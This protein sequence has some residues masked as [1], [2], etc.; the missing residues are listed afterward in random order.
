MGNLRVKAAVLFWVSEVEAAPCRCK[1][2]IELR[3][4]HLG[5]W[6]NLILKYHLSCHFYL[7]RAFCQLELAPE[8]VRRKEDNQHSNFSNATDFV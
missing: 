4:R 3:N 7:Q 6:K 8:T 1:D 5:F 2:V